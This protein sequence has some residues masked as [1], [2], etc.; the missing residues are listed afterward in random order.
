MFF[1]NISG[2]EEISPS[3]TSYLNRTEASYVEKIVTHLLKMGVNNSQI[4]VITPYDGQKKYVSEHM[5]RAG[6]LAASVYEEIEVNSVDAFQGREK[7]IILVSCVRSS[8]SQGIGFLADP[9]RLNV[10]LTRAR[11]GLVLLGN[12]R[13]LSKN[14][15]S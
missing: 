15:V 10:A 7:E 13:V 3:G 9:R 6:S 12:A 14:P 2:M 8:E 11:L 1:W 4:G 5:R